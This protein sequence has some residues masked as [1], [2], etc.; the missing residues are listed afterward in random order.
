[1]RMPVCLASRADAD[2]TAVPLMGQRVCML[3][4][5]K[6]AALQQRTALT[7]AAH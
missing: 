7:S 6:G 3:C 1:V 2:S 5:Q 4:L